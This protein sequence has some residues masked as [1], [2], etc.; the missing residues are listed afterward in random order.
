MTNLSDNSHPASVETTS[1]P[2]ILVVDD[3]PD[4]E[5]LVIQKFRRKIRKKE[6]S[7]LFAHNGEAALQV[8]A[9]RSDIDMVVTDINM[10]VMDGLTLLSCLRKDHPNVKAIVV[11][12]YGD[13]KNIREGM[14]RGAFDF[15]T[16]PL[17]FTDFESTLQKTMSHIRGIQA[18]QREEEWLQEISSALTSELRL[19]VLLDKIMLATTQLLRA[20]RSTLFL[21]DSRTNTLWSRVAQGLD[22]N[23]IR[24]PSDSGIAGEAFTEG[25]TINLADAYEDPRF[26]QKVDQNTGFR[27]RSLLTMPIE[28]KDGRRL[29]VVQ[30]LNKQGG[31][32]NSSDEQRVRALT[33]QAAIAIENARLFDD[34]LAMRNYN[35]DILRSLSNGVLTVDAGLNVTKAN[36]AALRILN[37]TEEACLD[38][39]VTTVFGN[40][41]DWILNALF[42]ALSGVSDQV[43]DTDLSFE[44][45]YRVAINATIT[46][47]S[48]IANKPIGALIIF[49]DI[50]AEKRLRT[51]MSRYMPKTV[52]DR[53]LEDQEDALTGTAQTASVLFSDIRSFTSMSEE[54]G[55]QRT[56]G[57]LN[58]YFENMVECIENHNGILDK[59]IGDA[60]MA[61][62]GVPFISSDDPSNAIAT[63]HDMMRSLHALNAKR[64]TRGEM[65]LYIGIG[66]NTGEVVA[67]N[68]GSHRRMNYTVIGDAVNL[69]SRLE[70]ATKKYDTPLL[71]SRFTYEQIPAELQG[72][73]REIDKIRV[74]GRSSGVSVYESFGLRLD[75]AESGFAERIHLENNGMLAYRKQNWSKAENFFKQAKVLTSR[76]GLAGVYLP[77][78][79]HYMKVDPGPEWDGVWTMRSK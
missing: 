50:S 7:I 57:L 37:M 58:E 9:N 33:A 2:V 8:L 49:E 67:G 71:I 63:A 53:L 20:Q 10:P 73:F 11:S 78:I 26:N 42:D 46:P 29:G 35:E 36:A 25:R 45:G 19:E 1:A 52:V 43:L 13:M 6:L 14:N 41:N 22:T 30:I 16:K 62:F 23:T 59:Y 65:P 38:K 44:N 17:D 75:A 39:H 60:I 24:I 28:A 15:L 18:R 54:L 12:A 55:A 69:A 64:V 79:H 21:H 31:P 66:I 77:R 72:K 48:N 47:L 61:I 74:R 76:L 40:S 27:T 51:S 3:E 32:F 5:A 56:V 68:I 34:V 4:V 70:S